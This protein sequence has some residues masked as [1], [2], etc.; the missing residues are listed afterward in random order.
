MTDEG[1]LE[2]W[3]ERLNA[4]R[5]YQHN[6]K[7]V[8]HKPLL[9]LMALGRLAETGSSELPWSETEE[10]L[11]Q[12]DRRVRTLDPHRPSSVCGLPVH[13]PSHRRRVAAFT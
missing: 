9:V 5:Q 12:P 11:G 6:G 3:V 10:T 4:L 2:G 7:R 13:T 8:P 1:E